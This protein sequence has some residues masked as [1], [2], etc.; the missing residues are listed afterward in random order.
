MDAEAFRH[1]DDHK[2][3]LEMLRVR[4]ETNLETGL[5]VREADARNSEYGLNQMSDPP[6]TPKWL[7]FLKEITNIFAIMLWVGAIL[8]FIAYI[9]IP[10]DPSNFYLGLV[11]VILVL[12]MG[13]FN[14]YFQEKS[15]AIMESF[16]SFLP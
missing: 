9:I 7:K 2:I 12:I 1:M 13:S 10:A 4:L 8:C 16:K 11:L 5:S 15:E 6:R 14:F 3:P